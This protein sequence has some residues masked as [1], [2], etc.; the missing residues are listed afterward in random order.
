ML[1]VEAPREQVIGT[2]WTGF[3]E[4]AYR[5]LILLSGPGHAWSLTWRN[6]A[7]GRSV[8]SDHNFVRLAERHAPVAALS[9]G[10]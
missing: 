3:G 1:L 4:F 6:E 9:E 2:P 8:C 5:E 7:E 10:A